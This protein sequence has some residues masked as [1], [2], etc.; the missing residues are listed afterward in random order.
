MDTLI[1]LGSQ[2]ANVNLNLS[3]RELSLCKAASFLNVESNVAAKR[4]F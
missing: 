3:A 4:G 1:V 2:V